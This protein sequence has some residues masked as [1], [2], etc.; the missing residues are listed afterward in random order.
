MYRKFSGALFVGA[1][2]AA[3]VSGPAQAAGRATCTASLAS[4]TGILTIEAAK[5]DNVTYA[6]SMAVSNSIP[7]GFLRSAATTTSSPCYDFATL[8][9]NVLSVPDIKVGS[10]YYSAKL[11]LVNATT[12]LYSL[13]IAAR[14]PKLVPDAGFRITKAS[15]PF[16]TVTAAGLATL[17]YQDRTTGATMFQTASDGLTFST[18]TTLTYSNRAGDSR[19]TLMPDGKTW[20]LYQYDSVAKT[21]GSYV[22]T[23]GNTFT[24]ETGIRYAPGAEDNYSMGVYDTYVATDGSVIL[25]YL[26][27]LSS[28]NNLRLARST[29]NGVTFT[30]YKNN[31]LGDAV[32]NGPFVDVKTLLLADGRRRIICMRSV[33]IHSFI[34]SDGLT[35]T[36]ESGVRMK[37]SD[38]AAVGV[39]I[40]SLNDPVMVQTKEGGYRVY[41]AAATSAI[42]DEA[43]GNLDWGIVSALWDG[44]GLAPPTGVTLSGVSAATANGTAISSSSKLTLNWTKPSGYTPDHYVYTVVDPATL[45][46]STASATGT[47]GSLTGL[48]SGTAYRVQVKA[49]KDAKCTEYANSAEAT[50]TTSDEYWQLQGTGA[51][52]STLTKAV[53]DGNVRLAVMRYGS[54]APDAVKNRLQFYYGPNSL[55]SAS[56]LATALTAS[57]VSAGNTSTYLSFT[58]AAGSS[59]LQNPSTAATLIK[60]VNAGQ[61]LP[62]SAAAGGN[63]RI[64]FEANGTDGKARIFSLDSQDGYVGK[65]FNAS[66]DSGVCKTSADYST[67]GG[68]AP[69]PVIAIESDSGG[70]SKIA[71]ARQFKIGFPMQTDWRWNE[72]VGTFMVFTVDDISGCSVAKTNHA[73]AVWSGSKWEV[74]YETNGCPKLFTYAQ[75]M[76]P[77]HLGGAK[78]K[79]YF[80]DI[81]NQTGR[82]S[83]SPLPF[84]GPKKVMYATGTGSG[85]AVG[86]GD[87]EG[88]ANARNV[89]FLWPDG[90]LLD[91]AAE[92]YIDDFMAVAPTGSLDSQVF[93]VAITN[94]TIPPFVAAAFLLNP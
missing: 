68:C 64:Y 75:A 84:L 17:G 29:D 80:G 52:V 12:N 67:G 30:F 86:F 93:Y 4:D 10:D 91:A 50:G 65:D 22:S 70:N 35:Y 62:L 45:D 39:T 60:E 88:V 16:A 46:S 27:E 18:P 78:Y 6:V 77:V 21:M 33:E 42:A 55:G 37:P 47:S 1:G 13:D 26:G 31:V 81:S 71:N 56:G 53:S 20:R 61:A 76:T 48:K 36:R 66:T 89:N 11:K 7:L 79:A 94:G 63:V 25:A 19:K 28:K 57:E 9:S 40:Y 54:D 49:C 34:S 82:V 74:Q 59:G 85:D 43:A 38:F 51:S 58:S 5:I 87:W 32:E 24:A 14:N 23:D 73:Y 41:A 90:T 15:N 3:L 92:G 83:G 72:D 2:L 8:A 69:K 44:P